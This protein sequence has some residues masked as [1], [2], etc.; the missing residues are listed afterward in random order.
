MRGTISPQGA[1]FS[2]V[3]LEDR[4]PQNHPLRK[5]RLLVDAVLGSMDAQLNA[6][7]SPCGGQEISDTLIGFL[8]ACLRSKAMGGR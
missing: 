1:M 8:A 6:V 4:V 3:S 7:Y 5:L 2:Y